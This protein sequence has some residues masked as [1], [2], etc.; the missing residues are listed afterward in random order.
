VAAVR[1]VARLQHCQHHAALL[2]A[3][4]LD[5]RVELAHAA[6][7]VLELAARTL[8]VAVLAAAACR[9]LGLV[10]E[11]LHLLAPVGDQPLQFGHYRRIGRSRLD[12][13]RLVLDLHR[14]GAGEAR[15][16]QRAAGLVR[17]C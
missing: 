11:L 9:R 13:G 4:L 16:Q 5:D 7:P 15:A 17:E 12:S 6:A 3:Q 1:A 8:H 14:R 2:A 10:E